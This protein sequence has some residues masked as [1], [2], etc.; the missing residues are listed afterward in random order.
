MKYIV[1]GKEHEM[2]MRVWDGQ[3]Y[4]PDF[5]YE[6][7]IDLGYDKIDDEGRRIVT[8]KRYREI[9]DYWQSEVDAANSGEW[10]EQ[11]GDWREFHAQ[12]E[13]IVFSADEL[14]EYNN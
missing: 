1:N 5:F 12:P 6:M 8:A 3:Q 4:S 13:E 2:S 9:V 10:S 11:F 14:A 7:E